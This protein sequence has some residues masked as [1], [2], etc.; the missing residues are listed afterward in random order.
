MKFIYTTYCTIGILAGLFFT[1]VGQVNKPYSLTANEVTAAAKDSDFNSFE[2]KIKNITNNPLVLQWKQAINTLPSGWKTTICDYAH[3]YADIPKGINTMDT[4]PPGEKGFFLL[5]I[6]PLAIHNSGSL[7][8]ILW[9]YS[10]PAE[11]DTVVFNISSELLGLTALRSGGFKLYPVPASDFIN[12]EISTNAFL[13]SGGVD[14]SIQMVNISGQLI[15]EEKIKT[16]MLYQINLESIPPGIYFISLNA[17]GEELIKR[18]IS[19][20]K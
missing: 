9:D 11:T 15:S 14:L 5:D 6:N 17:G 20:F 13:H 12:V 8:L 1:S 2:I 7:K 19:I 10:N 16:P 18:K 3:C 4:L